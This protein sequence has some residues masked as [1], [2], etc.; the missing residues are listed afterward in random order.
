MKLQIGFLEFV[1]LPMWRS[2]A[3]LHSSIDSLVQ[4]GVNNVKT[5]Q[6]ALETLRTHKR[7]STG[8]G[9]E[10]HESVMRYFDFNRDSYMASSDH[11][12]GPG[13]GSWFPDAMPTFTFREDEMATEAPIGRNDVALNTNYVARCRQRGAYYPATTLLDDR[14]DKGSTTSRKAYAS[15]NMASGTRTDPSRWQQITSSVSR[16]LEGVTGRSRDRPSPGI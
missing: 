14:E 3:T 8:Q 5:Y 2:L 6:Q 15:Q 1:V 4:S 11:P 7:N 13:L 12:K 9:E 10:T 16:W